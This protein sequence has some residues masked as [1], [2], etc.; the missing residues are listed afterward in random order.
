MKELAAQELTP[1][2]QMKRAASKKH[3]SPCWETFKVDPS[4]LQARMEID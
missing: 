4:T 3:I 2:F 1:E